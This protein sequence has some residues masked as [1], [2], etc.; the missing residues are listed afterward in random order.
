[1]DEDG[2]GNATATR[3][4]LYI[5]GL[6]VAETSG[7]A[8]VGFDDYPLNAAVSTMHVGSRTVAGFG[9]AGDLDDVQVYGAELS[10]EQV[11]E[12]YKRP[13]SAASRNFSILN[14]TW[15]AAPAAFTAT[16]SSSPEGSYRLF[17]SADLQ[18]WSP[19]GAGVPGSPDG[20]EI[21]LTDP[22]PPLLRQYYRVERQ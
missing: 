8:M 21:Q 1:L 22:A 4:R 10:R 20:L 16:V 5:N 2:F 6:R 12:L 7:A 11:W 13:G 3:A 14:A 9:Y 15:S 18:T 17:R 19:V